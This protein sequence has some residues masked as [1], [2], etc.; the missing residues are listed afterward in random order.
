MVKCNDVF[1]I[2]KV[3][4]LRRGIKVIF[5][6]CLKEKISIEFAD[7]YGQYKS[8]KSEKK[9]RQTYDREYLEMYVSA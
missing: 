2:V 3:L 8:F 5:E 4:R 1:K 6:N 7:K 9:H